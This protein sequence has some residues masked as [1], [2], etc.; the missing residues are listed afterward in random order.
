MHCLLIV[1][2]IYIYIYRV[3]LALQDL[4]DKTEVLLHKE[5]LVMLDLRDHKDH[6]DLLYVTNDKNIMSH[7]Y[8]VF[9]SGP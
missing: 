5:I 4:M 9:L 1:V 6:L 8:S 3:R 2:Y 7:Y